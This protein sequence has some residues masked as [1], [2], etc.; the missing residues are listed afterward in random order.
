VQKKIDT[1]LYEPKKFDFTVMSPF[2]VEGRFKIQLFESE[3]SASVRGSDTKSYKSHSS[4]GLAFTPI[5]SLQKR[6]YHAPTLL[7]TS[8]S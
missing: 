4:K 8:R 3:H 5:S 6:K 2:L 7:D 1:P